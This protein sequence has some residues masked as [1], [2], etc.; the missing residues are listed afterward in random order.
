MT[1]FAL[2]LLLWMTA[3]LMMGTWLRLV[4]WAFNF[5]GPV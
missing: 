4:W 5:W 2:A 3:A 1:R